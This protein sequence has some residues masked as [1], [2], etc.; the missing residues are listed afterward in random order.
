MKKIKKLK[1]AKVVQEIVEININ[2]LVNKFLAHEITAQEL[3]I[4]VPQSEQAQFLSVLVQEREKI[5]KR[6]KAQH[7][8]KVQTD[9][10]LKVLEQGSPVNV[11][12]TIEQALSIAL[13]KAKSFPAI[14]ATKAGIIDLACFTLGIY[15]W[16]SSGITN[17]EKRKVSELA[18]KLFD[19]LKVEFKKTTLSSHLNDVPIMGK[20]A[21]QIEMSMAF[22]N[23]TE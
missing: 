17:D 2:E 12:E 13:D 6:E 19:A 23:V 3:A 15:A 9:A 20:K 22:P 14:T 21:R 5:Q 18:S 16:K 4:A 1:A 10:F 11:P 8:A 7:E